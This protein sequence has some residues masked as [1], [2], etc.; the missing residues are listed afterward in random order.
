MS[1]LRLAALALSAVIT[2]P[3]PGFAETPRQTTPPPGLGFYEPPDS[4]LPGTPGTVIWSRALSGVA[5]LKSAA[6]N[7]LVLYRSTSVD[8]K[9]IAVSGIIALPKKPAPEGGWPVITWAHG[10]LGSADKCAPSRDNT[11]SPAYK[12]NQAPHKLLDA[13]LDE[14]WAVVMTDY[15]GLGTKGPHPYLVGL[16]EARGI[17]D[18][19]L[20]ARELHPEISKKVA[21][22]GHSQGGQAALSA[23]AEAKNRGDELDL[24]GVTALAPASFMGILFEAGTMGDVPSEGAAFTA[25]FLTG[26]IAGDPEIQAADVLSD[27]ALKL[28]P[29]VET[30]CRVELSRT[31]SWG[32]IAPNKI[33]LEDANLLPLR[34]QLF[35]MHP[36]N[37]TIEVPVRIVQG[38]EDER[39]NP[40]Q[41]LM[42]KEQLVGKGAIIDEYTVYSAQDHFGILQSDIE[43]SKAWLRKRFQ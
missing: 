19:L 32:G 40:L 29:E 17:L 27:E 14:G 43:K 3:S 41:T 18:I 15:E 10:T 4:M 2:L 11:R 1:L 42:L 16:S 24:R 13:Y 5:A 34:A 39:V 26:A 21:I 31:D 30:K 33:L 36:G 12:F 38:L 28:F 37:L 20:A 35:K 7:E 22:V 8:G 23:A 9:P 25:L 6:S